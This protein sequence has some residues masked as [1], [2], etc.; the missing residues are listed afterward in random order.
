MDKLTFQIPAQQHNE[1][2][3]VAL[4]PHIRIP[5]CQ[6]RLASQAEA[7]EATIRLQASPIGESSAGMAQVQLKLAS[8]TLQL[9]DITKMK[10]KRDN[11]WCNI[12]R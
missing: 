10:E 12:V 9:Q 8:L 5:L 1:W 3:I 2:F 4:A 11:M 6:Q 7:L